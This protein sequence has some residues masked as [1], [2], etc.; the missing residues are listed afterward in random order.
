ML[1][2]QLLD[3]NVDTEEHTRWGGQ[4]C[5]YCRATQ[6]HREEKT[7]E[8]MEHISS[9]GGI[10]YN[11]VWDNRRSVCCFCFL[12]GA[13]MITLYKFYQQLILSA[14]MWGLWAV[15]AIAWGHRRQ[16]I[17]NLTRIYMVLEDKSRVTV[18]AWLFHSAVS[19]QTDALHL[20]LWYTFASGCLG[21]CSSLDFWQ[22]RVG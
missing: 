9:R 20:T 19:L 10:R 7:S 18:A 17:N 14:D 4:R 11:D 15:F 3:N 13:A 6:E 12:N 21:C 16:R 2:N 1:F 22:W 5:R 8:C